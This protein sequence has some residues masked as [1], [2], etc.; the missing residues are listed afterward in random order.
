[1]RKPATEHTKR[2]NTSV[3]FDL[4]PEDFARVDRGFI[5]AI[6]DGH[7]THPETGRTVWNM[8]NYAFIADDALSP[9]TVNP[10]LWRQAQLNNIH[11]LFEVAPGVWQARGYDI[12]N[13]TFIAGDTGW[14]VIDPLTAEPCAKA[15]LDLANAHLG[16]RP[17]R[18]GVAGGGDEERMVEAGLVGAAAPLL[19][20]KLRR[21]AAPG[22]EAAAVPFSLFG[23][24]DGHGG[25]AAAETCV[26]RM[27]PEL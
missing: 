21:P 10:S 17:R 16:E 14:I 7:V 22:G 27:L 18:A 24:F 23:V 13:I 15:C 4:D 19:V 3:E 6:P 25:K 5:A 26:A 8:S 12:S 1:M 20:G 9:D 11:G 2:V